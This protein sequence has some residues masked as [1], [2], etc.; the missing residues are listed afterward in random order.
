MCSA[1]RDGGGAAGEGAAEGLRQEGQATEHLR[2]C[3]VSTEQCS[4][5]GRTRPGAVASARVRRRRG[6]RP[7]GAR[8]LLRPLRARGPAA[9]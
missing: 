9:G 4:G 3:V 2:V 8:R 5:G 1:H 7:R 6:L